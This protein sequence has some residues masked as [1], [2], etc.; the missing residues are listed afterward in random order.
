MRV[1]GDYFSD[2]FINTASMKYSY[3]NAKFQPK[4][5][6]VIKNKKRKVRSKKGKKK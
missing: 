4:R 1:F 3:P 2:Y 5:S 6:A